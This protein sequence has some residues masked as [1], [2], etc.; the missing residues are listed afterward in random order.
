MLQ[1]TWANIRNQIATI[2]SY[3]APIEFEPKLYGAI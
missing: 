3:R 2:A 1:Q